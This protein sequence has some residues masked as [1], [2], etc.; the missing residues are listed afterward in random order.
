[1][2]LLC[3]KMTLPYWEV[4]LRFVLGVLL[5]LV[6]TLK[7][8]SMVHEMDLSHFFRSS[9]LE[10]YMMAWQPFNYDCALYFTFG[11]Y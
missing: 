6:H 1:M 9:S 10:M 11:S 2:E 8:E 3:T 5:F 7:V 4:N